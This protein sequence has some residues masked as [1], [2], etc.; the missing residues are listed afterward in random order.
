M[1]GRTGGHTGLY[2]MERMILKL[3]AEQ[4][5]FRKLL[6]SVSLNSVYV[7]VI[8]A[9]GKWCQRCFL[10]SYDFTVPSD[11]IRATRRA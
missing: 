1:S 9:V 3:I 8:H 4:L 2:Y 7:G 11:G 5:Q 6:S 10:L